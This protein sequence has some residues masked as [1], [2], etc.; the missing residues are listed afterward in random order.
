MARKHSY[1]QIAELF[2]LQS[3]EGAAVHIAETD[4]EEATSIAKAEAS[5]RQGDFAA[6]AKMYEKAIKENPADAA[7][8]RLSLAGAYECLENS[9]Q[10]LRQYELVLRQHQDDPEPYVGLSAIYKRHGRYRD[11]IKRMQDAIA[12][13]PKNAFLHFK[14][15]ELLR[16]MGFRKEAARAIQS[17]ILF[18]PDDSFY[19]YWAGDLLTELGQ[20]GEALG[21]LR[22]AIELSPGDDGLYA[23]A[24]VAFFGANRVADAI[25]SARLASD[26]DPNNPVYYS[27]LARYLAS[28]GREE[29]AAKESE[30]ASAMDEFDT[31]R[32]NR[33]LK[34]L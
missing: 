10:A 33:L 25:K 7:A 15:A 22:A 21:Y 34:G 13:D 17:A 24:S 9:P 19:H 20:F 26:L 32:L 14:L 5:M 18:A 29:D 6:A 2:G 3:P 11:G 28:D 1:E 16:D 30:R 8:N 23:R 12:L 31:D 27:L 4:E